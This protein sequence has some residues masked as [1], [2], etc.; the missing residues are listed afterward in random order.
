MKTVF[1]VWVAGVIGFF[2]ANG[3]AEERS[4][5]EKAFIG[6]EWPK[7]VYI[8]GSDA[9]TRLCQYNGGYMSK[10]DQDAPGF[11]LTF[12]ECHS[13]GRWLMLFEAVTGRQ[14]KDAVVRVIDALLLAA[15]KRNERYWTNGECE[16][17]GSA[18]NTFIAIA[19]KHLRREKADWR[20]GVRAAWIPNMETGKNE[21]L[22]TRQVVCWRPTPP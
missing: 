13:D 17:N 5:F 21:R 2:C 3:Y 11:S 4:D 10:D 19:P 14:G 18:G 20:T 7:T 6:R 15:P 16:L 8:D 12:L 1:L 22:S 9:L